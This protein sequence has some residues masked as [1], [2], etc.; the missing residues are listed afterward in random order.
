MQNEVQQWDTPQR[1]QLLQHKIPDRA[2][3]SRLPGK[4]VPESASYNTTADKMNST[5]V[6]MNERRRNLSHGF[7]NLVLLHQV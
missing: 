1:E 6:Q 3:C 5:I 2:F 4:N 7:Y